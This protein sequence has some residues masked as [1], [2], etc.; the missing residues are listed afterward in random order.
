LVGV[1][2]LIGVESNTAVESVRHWVAFV[3]VQMPVYIAT[4][5]HLA[6]AIGSQAVTVSHGFGISVIIG[7]L[8]GSVLVMCL[9]TALFLYVRR[10]SKTR[11]ME[12]NPDCAIKPDSIQSLTSGVC[13]GLTL[14]PGDPPSPFS[15]CPPQNLNLSLFNPSRGISDD[16]A[17]AIETLSRSI[18][19]KGHK[20]CERQDR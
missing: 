12:L 7:G 15:K 14:E 11:E 13:R 16:R 2:T 18:I 3:S 19:R 5:S 10:I 17:V 8:C 6:F 1:F 9:M 4:V 20:Y